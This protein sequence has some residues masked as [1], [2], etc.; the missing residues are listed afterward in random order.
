[1]L[2]HA[3]LSAVETLRR[4]FDQAMLDRQA[5][6]ERLNAD[7]LGGDL[8]W[9]SSYT[10]PGEAK[11]PRVRADVTLDWPTWSQTALRSWQI[12]GELDEPPELGIEIV[13]R[14]QQLAGAPDVGAV[15]RVLDPEGPDLGNERL[16]LMSPTLEQVFD[17]DLTAMGWAVEF[18][19]DGTYELTEAALGDPSQL[20]AVLGGFGPWVASVLVRLG[21]LRLAYLPPS[22]LQEGER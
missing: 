18:A 13:V 3:F 5:G 22:D 1:M 4:S 16:H 17:T 21:D 8:T 19:Y 10:L 12:E 9:E 20:Q 15:Q 6:D 14:V 11:P 7:L 2:D